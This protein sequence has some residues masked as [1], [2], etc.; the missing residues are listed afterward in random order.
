MYFIFLFY[1]LFFV[2]IN[3]IDTFYR[4]INNYFE[5]RISLVIPATLYSWNK[6]NKQIEQMICNSSITPRETIIIISGYKYDRKV[7]YI[8]YCK[9]KVIIFYRKNQRNS[10]SNKNY[11]SKYTKCNYISYFDSDDIMSPDRIKTLQFIITHFVDYDLILHMY[12]RNY[13]ILKKSL[14]NYNNIARYFYLN[15]SYITKLYRKNI[16]NHKIEL[17]GCCHFLPKPYHIS[18]GWITI[19]KSMFILE[20]FNEDISI[21]R[22]EDSEYN[23]RVI[24]KGY[25]ALIL[26]MILGFY[27]RQNKCNLNN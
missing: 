5:K 13:S 2:V 9:R 4:T 25:K 27:S 14:Y 12:T 19:K 3:Y 17:W 22:A 26:T 24:S 16:K 15:S 23:G 10:A 20:K 18:N 7:L 8:T 1:I 11:G 6:C 21:Q